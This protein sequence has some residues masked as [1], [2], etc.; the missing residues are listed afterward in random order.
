MPKKFF[1]QTTKLTNNVV[2]Y[3]L[4]TGGHDPFTTEP[5]EISAVAVDIQTFTI[6]GTFGFD[7]EN[8]KRIIIKPTDFSLVHDKALEK[9][10]IKREDLEGGLDQGVAFKQ[11]CDF[12]R[13]YAKTDSKWDAPYSAGY[14]IKGFDNIIMSRL[15]QKYGYV[16]SEGSA[17]LFHP[18]HCFDLMDI[19]RMWFHQ[20]EDG[21][22]GYS[23]GSVCNFFGV[24]TDGAHEA[25]ADVKMTALILKRMVE[26]QRKLN[27]RYVDKFRGA[28]K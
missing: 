4:E 16:D 11:F 5:L 9:N 20:T 22:S 28:F 3:D 24:S 14:N 17:K 27:V 19:C 6:K 25:M 12:C 21:P 7:E 15:C 13:L 2:I 18:S 1:K 26:F 10:G 23:L 8:N